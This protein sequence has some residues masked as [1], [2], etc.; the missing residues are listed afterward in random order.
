M[1]HESVL[2]SR[3]RHGLS[4]FFNCSI[5]SMKNKYLR[6]PARL[7]YWLYPDGYHIAVSSDAELIVHTD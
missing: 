4:L 6:F 3:H 2:P 1:T 5:T 7:G